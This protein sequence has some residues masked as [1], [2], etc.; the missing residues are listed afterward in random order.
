MAGVQF[1]TKSGSTAT[2]DDSAI[3]AL[4]SQVSG[5]LLREG[6][7]EYDEVRQIWNGMIDKR[8]ALI[9][10]CAT[11]ADVVA[12]VKFGREQGLLV[13]VR[14]A[15][16]NI[17]GNAVCDGGLMI[18]LSEMR[19]V[20]VD[21]GAR[22]ATVE[23]GATLGDFD[24]AAQKH[25]LATPLGINSTTGV[26]G[27]TLGG[28]FGWLSR[29]YGMTVDNLLSVDIVTADGAQLHASE[30]EHPDLFWSIRG[31][32]GNFGVVTQFE[33]QLHPVGPDVLSGLIVLPHDQAQVALNKYATFS[34]S[35][36]DD[37]N[38]WVVLRKAPPLPFLPEAVHGT[39]IIA[40]AICYA[41]DPAEGEPLV[42]PIR[43]FGQALGEHVG[44]Q[45]YTAWQQAFDPL[46]TPGARNYWKSHNFSKISAG[47][48]EAIVQGAATL[49]SPQCEVFIGAIG[50]ATT[51]VAPDAMAYSH[52]D[53]KYVM[54]VHGRWDS[55]SEDEAG[56]AWAREVF[57]ATAP[58]ASKGVYVNFLTADEGDRVGAAY[59]PNYN[60]LVEVKRKYDPENLFRLNQNID[61]S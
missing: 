20:H 18:D 27:L 22:R 9:V 48:V 46:L 58:F 7:A 26:A 11:A 56:I 3:D 42:E 54:N 35:M 40:F 44:V 38:V 25:G 23:G 12:A 6:Q 60:R 39:D 30:Q 16:H 33:F 10:R 29:K 14:G 53:A 15:G 37:L 57:K 24:A 2:V 8:P 49:P 59:G 17:A 55:P 19:A 1:S 43:S 28:G 13:A 5:T 34:Q 50:G 31:G 47:A 51:R 4:R 45:P 41:G 52:R 36:P 61:P 21:A 32:S